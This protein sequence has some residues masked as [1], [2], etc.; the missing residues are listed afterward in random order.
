MDA[1][2]SSPHPVVASQFLYARRSFPL[3]RP[4][5]SLCHRWHIVIPPPHALR[6]PLR[7][8]SAVRHPL[9]CHLRPDPLASCIPA[10]HDALPLTHVRFCFHL[11]CRLSPP[12]GHPCPLVVPASSRTLGGACGSSSQS[13]PEWLLELTRGWIVWSAVLPFLIHPWS[14]LLPPSLLSSHCQVLSHLG[15][16]ILELLPT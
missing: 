12:P 11:C 1:R 7:G 4:V 15:S 3:C 5:L 9:M 10:P 13:P 8:W 16:L 6:S 2:L 14:L